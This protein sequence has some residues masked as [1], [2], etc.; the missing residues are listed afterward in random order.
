MDADIESSVF[1]IYFFEVTCPLHYQSIRHIIRKFLIL[2]HVI[3]FS[4]LITT[5]VIVRSDAFLLLQFV[6]D[7]AT[8]RLELG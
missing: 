3:C 5:I 4:Q 8:T 7:G 2:I 6:G 1:L